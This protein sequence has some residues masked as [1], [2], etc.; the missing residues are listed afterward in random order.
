MEYT[1]SSDKTWKTAEQLWTDDAKASLAYA[2][3]FS[4]EKNPRWQDEYPLYNIGTVTGIIDEKYMWVLCRNGV[5]RRCRTDYMTC[6]T[7][8][9]EVD[10]QV[11][12]KYEDCD[13]S[14]PVVVGFWNE[15]KPCEVE[16]VYVTMRVGTTDS[17]FV[18]DVDK[19]A[20]A[21]IKLNSGEN[22]S[23]PCDPADISGWFDDQANAGA[24]LFFA[25]ACGRSLFSSSEINCP[26]GDWG[27][28]GTNSNSKSEGSDCDCDFMDTGNCSTTWDLTN[29]CYWSSTDPNLFSLSGTSSWSTSQHILGNYGGAKKLIFRNGSE[30][31]DK[32]GIELQ[33][34][35]S[36]SRYQCEG[37]ACASSCHNIR[38]DAGSESRNMRFHTP[39]ELN[40][41][42]IDYAMTENWDSCKDTGAH[43]ET[44]K[45]ISSKFN[46][47]GS[48]SEKLIA[49]IYSFEAVTVVR[50]MP[51]AIGDGG[52]Y[53]SCIW[54]S[55][56]YTTY[57]LRITAQ[58]GI[59]DG[60]DGIDP[61]GLPR[62]SSFES[63]IT[64]MYDALRIE[65]SVPDDE[66]ANAI[67]E[68]SILKG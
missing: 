67:I 57:G 61:T 63:S 4:S 41:L 24:A 42:K 49:Q 9:F 29:R 53:G 40:I 20:Y 17:C 68:L 11:A 3:M 26:V 45:L 30:A 33:M 18:W 5:Q 59:F 2:F 23:F 66:I 44:N 55:Q 27:T 50:S 8:A 31:V 36:V 28:S 56:K 16:R 6:D 21:N 46:N 64:E 14:R 25:V 54:T 39:L 35:K 47:Q 34:N 62:N 38:L 65:E 1:Y 37:A 51:G 32:I 12:V 48:Y 22:A 15:P 60:T 7:A 10:D 19:N 43:S 13:T 58:A 52:C